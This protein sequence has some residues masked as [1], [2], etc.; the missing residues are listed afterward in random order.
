M[1]LIYNSPHY[2][3]LEFSDFE[4]PAAGRAP[5]GGFEIMDKTLRREIFLAGADAAQFRASVQALAEKQPSPDDIDEF[6]GGYTGLMT[7]PVIA[8]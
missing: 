6:L 3:V 7:T 5:V 1:Q 2:C 8:H 4:A